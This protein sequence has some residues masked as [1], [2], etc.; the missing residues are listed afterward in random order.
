MSSRQI[1]ALAEN[2]TL[3]YIAIL[4]TVVGYFVKGTYDQVSAHGEQIKQCE[5][6]I[7]RAESTA[8]FAADGVKFNAE[9]INGAIV[10]I[11]KLEEGKK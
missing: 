3:G 9:R 8:N 10:R 6:R 4:V 5:I 7:D 11:Q 1:Q 2:F